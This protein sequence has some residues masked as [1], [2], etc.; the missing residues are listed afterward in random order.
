M[1]ELLSIKVV[2]KLWEKFSMV[3][4]FT[5][6]SSSSPLGTEVE[7]KMK[8]IDQT[9]NLILPTSQVEN[10]TPT[11]YLLSLGDLMAGLFLGL[12]QYCRFFL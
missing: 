7:R 12:G 3:L 1:N 6:L 5:L 8:S 2:H 4:S 10:K 11:L 9:Y